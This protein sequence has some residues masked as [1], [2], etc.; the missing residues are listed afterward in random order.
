[1]K[2]FRRFIAVYVLLCLCVAARAGNSITLSSGSGKP[3]DI[4]K[5]EMTLENDVEISALQISL[6]LDEKAKY[7]ASSAVLAAERSN[8]HSIAASE[9]DGTLTIVVY[10][11]DM[12]AFNGN[13][14]KLLS[15]DL[16][17]A[18]QPG[19]LS[20]IPQ[21][22]ILTDVTGTTQECAVTAGSVS[23]LCAQTSYSTLKFDLGRV[24]LQNTYKST[25]RV[26]NTGTADLVIT[27]LNFSDATLTAEN[28]FPLTITPGNTQDV[29]I[30]YAPIERGLKKHT[31]RVQ[32]NT[33]TE[34]NLIEFFAEPFAVNELHIADASGI[35][36]EEVEIQLSMNNMDPICG[37]Q[38]DFILPSQLKFVSGSFSLSDRK[39]DH[40]CLASETDGVL[41]LM[42][43]SVTNSAFADNDGVI[44]TFR[45][46]LDG[47]YSTTLQANSCIL[48]CELNGEPTNVTS[49]HYSGY[50]TINS[51][52]ISGD[53]SLSLG[54]QPITDVKSVV[55]TVTNYGNAPLVIDNIA[56][57]NAGFEVKEKFPVRLENYDSSHSFTL[58]FSDR[59][60]AQYSA[61][62][63]IY[64]N[65]PNA[66]LKKVAVSG[67]IYSPNFLSINSANDGV[68]ILL[69][70][71][72]KISGVQF[73][74][75]YPSPDF[76]VTESDIIQVGS[77]SDFAV[78]S[79]KLDNDTYRVFAYSLSDNF[80]MP[81]T[82]EV[83]H[84]AMTPA[85]STI[86]GEFPVT[87]EN[88]I[89]STDNLENVAS[90]ST[91]YGIYTYVN[92]DALEDIYDGLEVYA[93]GNTIYIQGTKSDDVIYVYDTQGRLL[94]FLNADSD[95]ANLELP[96]AG[97][98]IVKVNDKVF[99]MNI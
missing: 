40:L 20:L 45:L 94:H 88:V 36:D 38:F 76:E 53:S 21:D 63:L 86:F 66:R 42:A 14:G 67:E 33:V 4:V 68:D 28:E 98:Y 77:M 27:N 34:Y 78:M 11:V 80:L 96:T 6:P 75:T 46:K 31:I 2:N 26:T 99:K 22:V 32:S 79:R 57:D 35:S 90:N 5:V 85:E 95:T 19:Q 52:T 13:S 8:G 61:N 23:V 69:S 92:S 54:H 10:S 91:A 51:P 84:I 18:E 9:S 37:F 41:K 87:I 74:I 12:K 44:A 93:V 17:L 47:K 49:A 64:S 58:F 30:V 59:E 55:Y 60:L 16:Q 71:Y 25:L 50:V 73:D 83:I 62:M 70:N 82:T 29:V 65:D 81:D 56:F 24:P 48:T 97:I 39:T 43:Y 7:V 89:L 1:M 72:E 15:F 3:G